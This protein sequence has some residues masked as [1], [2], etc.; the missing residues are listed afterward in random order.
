[1]PKRS[2]AKRKQERIRG[3]KPHRVIVD[4][5]D[6]VVR[7]KPPHWPPRIAVGAPVAH[8][9]WILPL[10]RECM[11]AQTLKPLVYCFVTARNGDEA[12]QALLDEPWGGLVLT[13]NSGLPFY[14]RNERTGNP[15]D[16]WRASHFTALRND[17]RGLFLATSADV[18]VSCDTDILLESPT[19]IEELV[20]TLYGPRREDPHADWA[21]DV[22]APRTSFTPTTDQCYNAGRFMAGDPGDPKRIWERCT[23][24]QVLSKRPPM[25]IDIP[26]GV[27]AAHRFVWGMCKYKPHEQGEDVGFADALDQKKMRVGWRHDIQVRHVW[28]PEY[29]EQAA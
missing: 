2:K 8:R 18:F 3:P 10:W 28:G 21:W 20:T 17:L 13:R 24:D 1:M 14:S 19:V 4:G 9:E 6:M 29:L 12:T 26:M 27:F 11:Q 16:P 15:L 5:E 22:V 23:L 7:E 25:P